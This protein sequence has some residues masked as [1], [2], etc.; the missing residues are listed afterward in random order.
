MSLIRFSPTPVVRHIEPAP[1]RSALP[2]VLAFSHNKA[3]SSMYF[4]ILQELCASTGLSFVSLPGVLFQSGIAPRS[5][6][7]ETRFGETGYCYGGFRFF[8]D[9]EIP[10]L[11]HAKTTLLVRDPRDALVSSYYSMRYSHPLPNADGGLKRE[12]LGRRA[13]A[14]STPIDEWCIE[15]HGQIASSLDGYVAQRFAT[16]PN[17]AIYRYEDVIA[18]KR[19][20]IED[21]V[22]WYGWRI[23]T[24]KLD[25]VVA[26]AD[27]FPKV[28][29]PTRHIRQVHPG[30]HRTALSART[31]GILTEQ[32]EPYLRLF[33]YDVAGSD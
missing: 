11:D 23:P 8:P 14:E 30:N 20:W 6:T 21:V 32:F 10:L 7:V 28:A 9:Y 27:I 19:D 5:V 24:A 18:R 4:R 15:N 16:R 3:G 29:D 26:A 31:Q 22:S 13:S 25:R 33:G 1:S 17:V 12:L 2:S